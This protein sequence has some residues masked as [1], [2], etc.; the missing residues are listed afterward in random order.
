[1][2]DELQDN[3]NKQQVMMLVS[4]ILGIQ[5]LAATHM[6]FGHNSVVY[7]VRLPNRH[8]IVRTNKNAHVFAKTEHNLTILAHI[9]LPVPQV[10]ASDVT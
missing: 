1:M 2:H 3:I 7:D 8:V 9:G 4:D 5:P 6:T 10:L